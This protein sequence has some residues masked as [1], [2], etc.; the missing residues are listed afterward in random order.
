MQKSQSQKT[1]WLG[2]GYFE[3]RQSDENSVYT[4][5]QARWRWPGGFAGYHACGQAEPPA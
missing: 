1:F 4:L 3:I 5:T 2:V